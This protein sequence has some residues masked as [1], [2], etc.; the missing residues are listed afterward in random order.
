[1]LLTTIGDPG[2]LAASSLTWASAGPSIPS[3][4]NNATMSYDAAAGEI[5]MF[6]GLSGSA[7]LNDTWLFNLASGTWRQ[8]YPALS[9]PARNQAV[10]G[11]DAAAGEVVLFGG[12]TGSAYLNDTWLY[13]A[14]TNTWTQATPSTSPSGR[15]L[16]GM[17]YD[18]AAGEMVLFG[19]YSGT[20][21]LNDTWL[22]NAGTDVWSQAAPATSPATRSR[23]A[24]SYD[25]AAGDI[26]LF[27]GYDATTTTWLN[28]TWLYNAAADTWTQEAPATS[29][30]V[31]GNAAMSYNAAADVEVLFGGY[32]GS[33]YLNDTWTYSVATDTWTLESPATSP[34]L[35][36]DA[37]SAYDGAGTLEVLFGGNNGTNSLND[38]WTY[39]AGTDTWAQLASSATPANRENSSMVYDSASGEM[40]LFGGINSTG[41]LND[42][43]TYTASGGWVERFPAT[44]PPARFGATMVYDAA[45]GVVVLFGGGVSGTSFLSDTWTY[46]AAT[47]TWTQE[48]PATSPSARYLATMSYDAAAGLVVLFGGYNGTHLNDT[49]TYDVATDTWA[50]QSPAT[51]PPVRSRAAM[52]YDPATQD[53]ILFGGYSGSAY[54]SDTWVYNYGADTWTAESPTTTPAARDNPVMSYD[55]TLQELVLFGG[56][57][58]SG[59][60]SDTWTFNAGLDSWSQQSP[61]A[62][63]P[64]LADAAGAFDPASAVELFFGGYISGD[65]YLGA[66]WELSTAEANV[67]SQAVIAPGSLALL[68]ASSVAFSGV[69]LN[70]SPQSTTATQTLDIGDATGSGNGWNI[71][72]AVTSP[73]TNA[74]GQTLQSSD[75]EVTTSPSVACDTGSTCTLA[76]NTITYP[77]VLGDSTPLVSAAASS[78]MGNQTVT[79]AWAGTIPANAYAGSYTATWTLTLVSGP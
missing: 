69:T 21:P 67:T 23:F 28:D 14:A 29:P 44:S 79:V 4:R 26:V 30:S 55:T 49:W 63:P 32:S 37:M 78:G 65:N 3:V 66:T 77:F 48:T 5:V 39:N 13:D 62:S 41:I 71:Q 74:G 17:V 20:A 54:L 58:G 53:V 68:S 1:M 12:Y 9:P 10:M 51:S 6:G 70:A 7:Y 46:N 59:N 60:L 25:A 57:G 19:G 24:M 73:F 8:V 61:A 36:S 47:D 76:S 34:S 72:I 33:V 50:Q 15:D 2:T 52:A 27:G 22:Y 31:R 75:F 43:W 16:G 56:Y 45:S 11:Y 64:P 18:A 35:R 42:T 38:T 40:V